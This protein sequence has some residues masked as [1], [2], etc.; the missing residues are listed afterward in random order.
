MRIILFK[1]TEGRARSFSLSRNVILS[2]LLVVLAGFAGNAFILY[3]LANEDLLD[4][5]T[6]AIYKA[7][8]GE[9]GRVVEVLK[10]QSSVE[11]AAVGRRLAIMQA[12]LLRMEALGE[13]VTEVA[14]IDQS[15]FRFNETPALGGPELGIG[16]KNGLERSAFPTVISAPEYL[17]TVD[18]LSK[19]LKAREDQLELLE[20]LLVQRKFQQDIEL[21]GRPISKGWMSS[22][23]GRR[24][25]PITGSMAWHAG[26]DFA[27][28]EGA[29]VIAVASGV[30][31][32]ADDRNG[33]GK[34]V[35]L[36][37][38]GGYRTRYGH[39]RELLVSA[40]DVVKRGQVI[41][42]IGSTG[43]S[44]GPHVHFE[45]L[46]NGRKVDPKQYVARQRSRS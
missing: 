7:E 27:G 29:D 25:D 22:R 28:I 20:S 46:K 24:V 40:G 45:V 13:R 31:V 38:G 41:G 1:E 19:Q 33:Y 16:P 43:R 39:H 6:I 23:F 37:H 9:Y 18:Q 12:R 5:Q 3:K 14:K 17:S 36:N 34:L 4:A 44:T 10:E 8:M 21:A 15:E 11:M 35:E 42:H 30:V 2:C 32:F 26:V